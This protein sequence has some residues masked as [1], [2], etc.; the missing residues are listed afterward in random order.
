MLTFLLSVVT[1][2]ICTIITIIL[3]P[4]KNANNADFANVYVVKSNQ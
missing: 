2:R 3:S 1:A 4:I